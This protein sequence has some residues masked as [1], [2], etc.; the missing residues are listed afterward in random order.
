MI[1]G[2]AKCIG[3]GE[4][5][6]RWLGILIAVEV[7]GASECGFEQTLV[8]C[9]GGTAVLG[10]EHLVHGEHRLGEQPYWL[11]ALGHL[12]SSLSAFR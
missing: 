4:A 12:A 2:N 1:L 7:L 5:S 11:F 3:G 6:Q 9:L 10:N 8:T